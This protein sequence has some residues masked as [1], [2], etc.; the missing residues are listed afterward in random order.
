MQ[1]YGKP[2]A[3][4]KLALN[5]AEAHPIFSKY[6]ERHGQFYTIQKYEI[7]NGNENIAV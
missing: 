1:I 4:L 5:Y 2:N 3:E 6:N 7:K